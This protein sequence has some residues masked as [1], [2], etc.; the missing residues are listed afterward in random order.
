MSCLQ[1]A[2]ITDMRN[3]HLKK[4]HWELIEK[5]LNYKFDPKKEV[6]NLQVRI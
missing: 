3:P 1:L 6:L 2:V 5:S 4:R